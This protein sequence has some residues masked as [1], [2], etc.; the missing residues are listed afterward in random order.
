[1]KW[2]EFGFLTGSVSETNSNI[3]IIL[4]LQQTPILLLLSHVPAHGAA[5]RSSPPLRH[6][7]CT[8]WA[9]A[10]PTSVLGA[11]NAHDMRSCVPCARPPPF[12]LLWMGTAQPLRPSITAGTREEKGWEVVGVGVWLRLRE[13]ESREFVRESNR[14]K[15]RFFLDFSFIYCVYLFSCCHICTQLPKLLS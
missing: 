9:A 3:P 6:R 1:M 5:P 15:W 13:R 11:R 14:L 12:G 7:Q 4:L 8:L 10:A 2:V